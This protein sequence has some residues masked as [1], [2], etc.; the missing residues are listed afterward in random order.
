MNINTSKEKK[1]CPK[2]GEIKDRKKDFYRIKGEKIKVNGLCKP[3]LLQSN[4]ERRRLVKVK[5]VEY[6]GGKC[7]ACGYN[8]CIGSLD[9]HHLDPKEKDPKYSLFKTIF[10]KRLTDELDKCI[11]LCANCH[12]ELHYLEN[13]LGKH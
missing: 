11:L 1:K 12:R 4:S 6:L 2:C 8:K 3:C 7:K 9:F 10:N 13:T 5:A